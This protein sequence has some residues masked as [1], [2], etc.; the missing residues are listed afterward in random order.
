MVKGAI[1][2]VASIVALASAGSAPTAK[3]VYVGP[4]TETMRSIYDGRRAENHGDIESAAQNY[5]T[6]IS[7]L[8]S[9]APRE[10]DL[11][12]LVICDEP[13]PNIGR[14]MV[15]YWGQVV[16]KEVASSRPTMSVEYCLKTLSSCYGKMAWIEKTNPTWPYLEAVASAADGN[17]LAAF[18]KCQE[19][20]T[21]G[22][23]EE[24]VRKKARTLAAHI[25]PGML[26]QQ[27]M[28][29]DDW[30]AYNEYVRSGAQALDFATVSARYSAQDARKRGDQANAD[31]WEQRYQDLVRERNQ[32]KSR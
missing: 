17:Y 9:T 26:A 16:R 10:V 30:A 31:R 7:Y 23:G 12:K 14:R 11:S 4:I 2:T 8:E 13:V 15:Y 1:V 3:S 32:I 18:Q 6:A 20:A 21:L 22:G 5:L 25:K 27:Q 28:K 19:A 24:S 29:E